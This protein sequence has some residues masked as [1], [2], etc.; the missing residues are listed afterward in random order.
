MFL[1]GSIEIEKNERYPLYY[2]AKL[3]ENNWKNKKKKLN[4]MV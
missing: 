1:S 2:I 3:W 4:Y